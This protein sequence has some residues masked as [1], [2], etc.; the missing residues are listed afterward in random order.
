MPARARIT[1]A[2]RRARIARRQA[3]AP[4][5]RLDDVLAA[6]TAMTVLHP[7]TI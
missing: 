1:G 2:E 7:E 5:Y 4:Q 6:T 3:I